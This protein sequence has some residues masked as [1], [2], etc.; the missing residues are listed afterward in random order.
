M[1]LGSALNNL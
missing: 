1:A